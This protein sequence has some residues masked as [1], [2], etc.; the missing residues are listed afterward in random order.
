MAS[1]M[2]FQGKFVFPSAHT[3]NLSMKSEIDP[4]G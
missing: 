3:V 1:M 2:H 4:T